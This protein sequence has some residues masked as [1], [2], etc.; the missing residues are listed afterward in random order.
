MKWEKLIIAGILI[1]LL[2]AIFIFSDQI[3][4]NVEPLGQRQLE[5]VKNFNTYEERDGYSKNYSS[6][7]ERIIIK[8]PTNTTLLDIKLIS[9]KTKQVP[10]GPDVLVAELML[11]AFL[12]ISVSLVDG[13]AFYDLNNNSFNISKEIRWKYGVEYEVRACDEIDIIP[14]QNGTNTYNITE[15]NWTEFTLLSELPAKNIKI[16]LFT[17]TTLG[18]KIEWIP[19]IVGFE[20]SEW[21]V[22]DVT[23][24]TS[25]EFGTNDG[26][27]MSLVSINDTHYL[28]AYRGSGLDGYAV[29]LEV[30][31]TDWTITKP[32]SSTEY[33]GTNGASPSLVKINDTHYLVAYGGSAGKGTAKVLEVNLTNWSIAT[34]SSYQFDSIKGTHNSM[35]KI[36]DTHYL[37]TYTGNSDNGVA[38]VLEVNLTNYTI[39]EKDAMQ[40]DAST[41][42]EHSLVKINDTHY[43]NSY[44]GIDD[45]GNVTVLEVNLTNY[46]IT[47]PG[48]N[49]AFDTDNG[50]HNSLVKIND[51][52]Y[53]NSYSGIDGSG[54]VTVLEVDL[55]DW[56]ISEPGSTYAFDTDNGTYNSMVKINDT[57][58]LNAYAGLDDDGY[59]TVFEVDLADWSI[60]EPGSTIEF[61]TDNGTH[62][63]MVK[64][65]NTHYV[66]AYT[67]SAKD[68]YAIVLE[69]DL[70]PT[71]TSVVLN[72]TDHPSN[73][74][75][76][77]LT[78]Y[79]IG[80]SDY[81]TLIYDWRTE[82]I[83][84]AVLNMPF[85]TNVSTG[86][87]GAIRDYSSFENNGTLG[88]A[89]DGTQPTWNASGINGGAYTFDGVDDFINLSVGSFD[90]LDDAT[91]S[92]WVKWDSITT[93]S[94][95]VE[96]IWAFIK[97]DT[98]RVH[99]KASD[100]DELRL[101]NDI[102]DIDTG[103]T[104]TSSPIG[105]TS[106]HHIVT[107]VSGTTWNVYVDG[108]SV[109]VIS[110]DFSKDFSD[111]DDGFVT[112]IGKKRYGS[113]TYHN[114]SI[115]EVMIWN[116]TLSP[117]QILALY[118]SGAP[119]YNLT[120]SQET[121]L[122]ENW[123]VAVTPNNGA[124]DGSTVFSNDLEILPSPNITSVVLNATDHPSNLT[125][126]NLTAYPI[127]AVGY[128]TLIY[129]W[130]TENISTAVLNMPFD[131]NVSDET[132]G[133]VRD[134]SSFAN[135]G[136]LGN[137]TE[138]NVPTWNNT[139]TLYGGSYEFD[140]TNDYSVSIPHSDSLD[141]TGNQL[142]L[143]AWVYPIDGGL[144]DGRRIIS[145]RTDGGG[146]DVYSLYTK[147][148]QLFV[149]RIDG[150][151]LDSNENYVKNNWVHVVG[152]YNGSTK[153]IYINGTL[154]P[155]SEAKS[156]NIDSSSRDVYIGMREEEG[157]RFNGTIGEVRIYN[158]SLSAEQILALYN[159]GAPRYNLTVS[160]ETS[161]G[162]NWSVAVTPND[163]T[164]DGATVFSNDL[165]ILFKD[166]VL[167]TV[168]L[169]DPVDFYNT[170]N[171]DII[172]NATAYDDLNLTNMT[173]YT[174]FSGGFSANVTNS[175]P[176]NNTQSN[177]TVNGISEGYYV[178]NVYACDNS[179][180][181]AFASSN[182]SFTVS[183][184]PTL[185]SVILNATS[186]DNLTTANLTAYPIGAS[187]YTTLIYDWR[188]EN[189]STAVL[190][191]PFDT[192]VSDETTGAVRDY[193]S[194]AN[195]GTLGNGTEANVPT[196][197]NTF[198]LYGGSYDFDGTND[199]SVAIPDDPSLNITGT[200]I[201]LEVW[202]RPE[203]TTA[204]GG[205][206]VSKRTD[207]G[208]SEVYSLYLSDTGYYNFRLDG[209]DVASTESYAQNNWEHVVGVY[210]STHQML[211]VNGSRKAI[212][213]KADNID[214]SVRDVYVGMR[215][216]E[217]RQFNGLIGD[218][219]VY[220]RSLSP[221]QI[222]AL[223]NSG[224]PR[225][226][227]TVSNET[228]LYENWSV[229]VTPNNGD[230]DGSTVFSNDLEILPPPNITSVVLNATDHPSNLTTANLTVYPTGAVGY[231]TLIYDWRTENI[232]TA[233]LNMPFDTNVSDST[234]GAVRDYSRFENNATLGNGTDITRPT[235]NASGISGG[236]YQF[237]G[238]DDYID[239][240]TIDITSWDTMSAFVWF[241]FDAF[242]SY[243]MILTIRYSGNDDIRIWRDSAGGD[244]IVNFDD[245]SSEEVK[246]SFSDTTGWHHVGFN[247]NSSELRMYLDGVEVG[248]PDTSVSFNFAG[249]DGLTCIG[250]RANQPLNTDFL[251]DGTIDG[252]QIF[253][254]TLSPEQILALYNSGAPKYN[255]TVSQETT[256]YENWSVAVTPNNGAVD[257]S[258]V[259]SNDLEILAAG[260]TCTYSSG[261]WAVDCSD[262]C[263][264]TSNVDLGG[265]NMTI[266]G[267]GIFT[268]DA[269]NIT[270]Y[271]KVYLAGTDSSNIC[272]VKVINGGGFK[273]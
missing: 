129:D 136:T 121:S 82:N 217:A 256:L 140:G 47:E 138:A 210:N 117:E 244:L 182:R 22:W 216:G 51:T 232:S 102:D 233:V 219:K 145:K 125:T 108:N 143:E 56:S 33:D 57:H 110:N 166:E 85:D 193:S 119:N 66:N 20:I 26:D 168:N 52:H 177:F 98:D 151:D 212:S 158:R 252:V 155:A 43:L 254:R 227:L 259:F 173:L 17:D 225:Y 11:E 174:N 163:G 207:G 190:N 62:N 64:I 63:S 28:V 170:T 249:A 206:M 192:N 154:D 161:L 67:G 237:D 268:L 27:Q 135:N 60:S 203:S 5:G 157:R 150:T 226:N 224:A 271:N 50:R 103:V 167:P 94:T 93:G 160:N 179:T 251:F 122:Y 48:S 247:F 4:L 273:N 220:N 31:L 8:N 148:G 7:A 204:N 202:V 267:T 83:S 269:A 114:G 44:S 141:I 211:Y 87:T 111:L 74:T 128:T 181:C 214:I 116:R 124:V 139:F 131:T 241:K 197:N 245:G 172:F 100:S 96:A 270:D 263:N 38:T 92:M 68:G 40:F 213:S 29:V 258:T 123:S 198:T 222:L 3:N 175:S 86:D 260:D 231:T 118:N 239:V 261:N 71:I 187:D 137:G 41:T 272:T 54:N 21:A 152:V 201:T 234:T 126:A 61:D 228:S 72:A 176:I 238:A 107:T 205:R 105:T 246:T 99:L 262:Y 2:I 153:R 186:N 257:G 25:F 97:T 229:A 255:L 49:Y 109:P 37:N 12:N 18:E 46:T 253:N 39:T 180:N 76:A 208:G 16:G 35:V 159:S 149:F 146:N 10:S 112:Y 196:W 6:E 195:N 264:I 132:T 14:C 200:E 142:T 101:Y 79:P 113:P 24:G 178:W 188:T 104:S 199:Y 106:Y 115:D 65:N 189:V 77:N 36:N 130:R 45:G 80:A 70:P 13:M 183:S 235:W 169:N 171:Q 133:A 30:N 19:N 156:D 1:L 165:E 95:G 75:T 240:G 236:S 59:S 23:A 242:A 215:E 34:K 84:T 265:D 53:L 218:V 42:K 266:I 250:C 91:I 69:V 194:F 209:T 78:A 248:T 55:A 221:E 243:P 89:T 184:P 90:N 73:L 88:N 9:P 191:M 223:Y 127:G 144:G 81:T 164:H 185:D 15:T 147:L 162:E 32:G 58:Y 230:E 134:Y 120:V